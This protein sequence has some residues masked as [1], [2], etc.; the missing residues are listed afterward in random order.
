[1]VGSDHDN[2][3]DALESMIEAAQFLF[4]CTIILGPS[5]AKGNEPETDNGKYLL[6][7]A[8][9]ILA[10]STSRYHCELLLFRRF[11]FLVCAG[12]R[13]RLPEAEPEQWQMLT[14]S[15]HA[16][17]DFFH[18]LA[19][20]FTFEIFPIHT[21]QVLLVCF[22]LNT[23]CIFGSLAAWPHSKFHQNHPSANPS[24]IVSR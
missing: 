12:K 4:N 13:S 23:G 15:E 7:C 18:H 14:E 2:T 11:E 9:L 3:T 1:M 19:S 16:S 6:T 8:Y 17:R 20:W 21:F 22:S 5:A 24:V 10:Y